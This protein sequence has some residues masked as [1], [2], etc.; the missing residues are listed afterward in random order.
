MLHFPHLQIEITVLL[1]AM[2][3]AGAHGGRAPYEEPALTERGLGKRPHCHFAVLL[4]GLG[5]TAWLYT[6]TQGAGRY[7]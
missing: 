1:F 2:A 6:T 7:W 5:E 3:Q 4:E